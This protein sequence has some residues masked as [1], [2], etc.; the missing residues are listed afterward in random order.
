MAVYY[1]LLLPCA[2]ADLGMSRVVGRAGG[3]WIIRPKGGR[4]DGRT[5]RRT[6]GQMV[7]GVYFEG[8]LIRRASGNLPMG[9]RARRMVLAKSAR[10]WNP[11]LDGQAGGV[12]GQTG[13][14]LSKGPANKAGTE[15]SYRS[16]RGSLLH[17]F[18][19]KCQC[20]SRISLSISPVAINSW[21]DIDCLCGL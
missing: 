2:S 7:R 3:R 15:D 8:N 21:H 13:R 5:G 14:T 10:G 16:I 18:H 12:G 17:F 11:P 20:S 19:F 9:G 1:I 4:V 6:D